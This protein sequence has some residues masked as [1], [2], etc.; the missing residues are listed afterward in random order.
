MKRIPGKGDSEA[1][2]PD[3]EISF[4]WNKTNRKEMSEEARKCIRSLLYLL[5]RNT[6]WLQLWKESW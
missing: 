1:R 5:Q 6:C 3:V 4:E 2:N